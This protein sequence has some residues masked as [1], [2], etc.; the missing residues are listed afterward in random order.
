MEKKKEIHHKLDVLTLTQ[1][2]VRIK[3]ENGNEDEILN[4]ILELFKPYKC[5]HLSQVYDKGRTNHFIIFEPSP[6]SSLLLFS[7]HL[8]TVSGYNNNFSY[9]ANIKDGKIYGRGT[10]DMKGGIAAF[11]CSAIKWLNKNYDREFP[12]SKGLVLGFTVNEENGCLGLAK[13]EEINDIL[14]IFQRVSYCILAEPTKME[15]N[16]CHK[17][18]IQYLV[19]FKG[20]ASHASIPEQGINAIYLASKFINNIQN[21]ITSLE[22]IKSPLGPPKLTISTIKGGSGTNI[23]PEK[24]Q[25]IIDRRTVPEDNLDIEYEMISNLVYEVDPNAEI[26]STILGSPYLIPKGENNMYIGEIKSYINNPLNTTTFPAYSEAD[27]Y[28]NKY[29]IP[30]I[31]LGP[32]DIEQAHK[33]PEFIEIKQLKMAEEYYYQILDGFMNN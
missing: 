7:G 4:Y 18:I 16:F 10:C 1:E 6:N 31:I 27:I 5:Q 11:I 12:Q 19:K 22:L 32:G 25:I 20:K 8:D 28:Y 17:G 13:I 3:T 26:V 14:K 33:T 2:L 21:Y 24:C 9:E 15:I 30:T 23:V 29:N